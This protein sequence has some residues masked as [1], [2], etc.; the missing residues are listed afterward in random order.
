MLVEGLY[1][2]M[3]ESICM[4]F[5]LNVNECNNKMQRTHIAPIQCITP[6]YI[7]NA[8]KKIKSMI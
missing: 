5:L 6:F 2:H 8:D 1:G 4:P 3:H 7:S